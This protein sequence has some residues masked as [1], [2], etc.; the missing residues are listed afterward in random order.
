LVAGCGELPL[1]IHPGSRENQEKKETYMSKNL[2]LKG[3]AFGAI[4]ALGTT[5]FAGTPAFAAGVADSSVSLTPAVGSEYNVLAGDSFDLKSNFVANLGAVGSTL[6]FLVSDSAAKVVADVATPSVS[7]TGT[8]LTPGIAAADTITISANATATSAAFTNGPAVGDFVKVSGLTD[9]TK[10]VNGVF[11]VTS[12]TALVAGGTGANATFTIKVPGTLVAD[13]LTGT[14]TVKSLPLSSA[15]TLRAAVLGASSVVPASTVIGRAAD[16][17]YVVDSQ[18]YS[19]T[20]DT[21]LRLSNTDNTSTVTAS[22]TAWV[23]TNGNN[24][25]DDTE[26]VSTTRTVKFLA[27]ADVAA[28][29]AIRPVSVSDGTVVADVTTVPALNGEQVTAPQQSTSSAAGVVKV[30]FV[31]PGAATAVT[32][33]STSWD[34]TNKKFVVTSASLAH[35]NWSSLQAFPTAYTP[36]AVVATNT[37]KIV[38]NVVTVSNGFTHNLQVGDKIVLANTVAALA[39][40]GTTETV[41]VTSVPTTTSF[42]YAVPTALQGATAAADDV[43]ATADYVTAG[44]TK[45]AYTIDVVLRDSAQPGTYT[46]QAHLILWTGGTTF[47][48]GDLT[49]ASGTATKNGTLA[50]Y[51][52]GST[53]A[54]TTTLAGVGSANENTTGAIRPGTTS[55][56]FLASV[57]DKDGAAVGAGLDAAITVSAKS[58]IGTLTING[59]TVVAGSVVYAKTDANG[60]VVVTVGNTSAV[61]GESIAFG[62]NVQGASAT[63]TG[64]WTAAAITAI[65]LNDTGAATDRTAVKGGSVSFNLAVLDQY[66]SLVADGAYR[67]KAT[68]TGRTAS[69]SYLTLVGGKA[70]L[71]VTDGGLGSGSTTTVAL[72]AEKYTNGAFVVD[73]DVLSPSFANRTI[74]WALST[75]VDAITLNADG[76]NYP[77]AAADLSTTVTTKELKVLDL[78]TGFG[79]QSVF[80]AANKAVITG[81]VASSVGVVRPGAAVT[82]TAAGVLFHSGD[83]WAK[84]TITTITSSTGLFSVEAYSATSGTVKVA[85]ASVGATATASITV[86]GVAASTAAKIAAVAGSTTVQAGRAVDYT[87]TVTDK[88]SNVVAGFVLKATVVGAGSFAGTTAA[89]GSVSVTTDA[90]GKAIV[91]VLY[92]SADQGTATVTFADP[93]VDTT[94]V[95]ATAATEVGS[96]DSQIEIVK[97]RVTAVATFSKGKTVAFY[98]DGFKKWSKVSA[99]DADVVLYY[100]LK[101]GTH[102][103]TVKISGGFVTT[104]KFIVE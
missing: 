16:N 48:A 53:V 103:V 30:D 27:S 23:D 81:K 12:I 56:S 32:S 11:Q 102:T 7:V 51:T 94:I 91:K 99:S 77:G 60:Q 97:N 24:A 13:T 37:V 71:T 18:N 40:A 66:K 98:V 29:T 54:T 84:D 14:P 31:R 28:T 62:V 64:S 88:Y 50:S 104:E 42:T 79:T 55:A 86:A 82:F 69:T 6:K 38:N 19:A 90:K 9:G 22:V 46:A 25:I 65:D 33:A 87:A 4:V 1:E 45:F 61:D 47:T 43:A 63:I 89:D 76:A 10:T 70:T 3:L 85:V 34:A 49:V 5:A 41:T 26:K 52:T 93:T 17:S 78:R 83:V 73:T 67:V 8:A 35:G 95:S 72:I 58:S 100:N 2:T 96:T 36:S 20:D 75:E 44:P 57:V 21:W 68:L 80:D 74:T 101:K 39:K 15:A 59:T 92:S